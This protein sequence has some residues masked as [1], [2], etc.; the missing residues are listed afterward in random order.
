MRAAATRMLTDGLV[1][2]TTW[3][4][5]MRGDVGARAPPQTTTDADEPALGRVFA[6]NVFGHYCLTAA[7][8]RRGALDAS[9][10]VV[11]TGS[12]SA[13]PRDFDESDLQALRTGRAYESSKRLTELLVLTSECAGARRYVRGM[14]GGDDPPT[15][16][17]THP[18]V[19]ATAIA[20]QSALPA[21]L[22]LL[23]LHVARL[24]GS[25]WHL[26]SA[27]RGAASAVLVALGGVELG[28]KGKW[29]SATPGGDGGGF[30][31][32]GER[33]VRT[34]VEGWGFAGRA[35]EGEGVSVSGRKGWEPTSRES[36]EEFEALG[37]RVWREMEELRGEWERRIG[38]A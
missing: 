24:L 35:G 27:Y 6:A 23:V 19:V 10:R 15:F 26:V 31:W 33:V 22:A 1:R 28:S 3:P 29:G 18:G 17:L 14:I 4:E 38:E 36:V 30:V 34:E 20:G 9:S 21:L 13:A 11:W 16:Y 12:V 5:Y 37:G 32:G 2:A 7:L 25:P 8:A